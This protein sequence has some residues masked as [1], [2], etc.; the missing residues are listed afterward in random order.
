MRTSPESPVRSPWRHLCDVDRR[1]S[2]TALAGSKS[3]DFL[4]LSRERERQP[5]ADHDDLLMTQPIAGIAH[6]AWARIA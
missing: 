3:E 5:F 2:L 6:I 1:T 4:F